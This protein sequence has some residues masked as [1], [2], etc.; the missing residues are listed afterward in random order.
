[1]RQPS[2]GAAGRP[3]Q[4]RN[5]LHRGWRR[6]D[7]ACLKPAFRARC[8]GADPEGACAASPEAAVDAGVTGELMGVTGELMRL[9]ASPGAAADA[10][11]LMSLPASCAA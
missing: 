8:P 11:E 10:G 2:P 4:L 6:V 1:M 5:C 7:D 9:P 3:A